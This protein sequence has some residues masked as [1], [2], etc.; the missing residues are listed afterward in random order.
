MIRIRKPEIAS[1]ALTFDGLTD[2]H[3][4]LSALDPAGKVIATKRVNE[5]TRAG[6]ELAKIGI[7]PLYR[8]QQEDEIRRALH[9][10]VLADTIGEVLVSLD[11]ITS[12][13]EEEAC[14]SHGEKMRSSSAYEL[15]SAGMGR[16]REAANSV[17]WTIPEPK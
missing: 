17:G 16:T 10:R 15:L 11:E 7:E 9:Y 14:L 4:L 5:A 8:E 3:F 2:K 12:P 13:G 1:F 6:C